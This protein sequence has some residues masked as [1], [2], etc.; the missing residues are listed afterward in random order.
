MGTPKSL[1]QGSGRTKTSSYV[2]AVTM[3]DASKAGVVIF[4]LA[5]L[6]ISTI[7]SACEPPPPCR[8][9]KCP[10]KPARCGSGIMY[11]GL[12]MGLPFGLGVGMAGLG[13]SDGRAGAMPK[14]NS[15]CRDENNSCE[16]WAKQGHCS[17]KLY[18]FYMTK[19]CCQSCHALL[20]KEKTKPKTPTEG[21]TGTGGTKPV[22]P[23]LDAVNKA[24]IAKA[25]ADAA[26][27][28]AEE[29]KKKAEEDKKTTNIAELLKLVAEAKKAA[30][31]AK[32]AAE[33]IKA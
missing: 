1:C 28:K 16:T 29:D 7:Y 25:K 24:A 14:A 9:R 30:K 12:G 33:K 11:P 26:K 17:K 13:P 23:D 10:K 5:A 27:K 32:E 20:A 2:T 15:R 19:Y 21:K 31:M 18:Y 4:L 3:M 22:K 6:Q 8:R